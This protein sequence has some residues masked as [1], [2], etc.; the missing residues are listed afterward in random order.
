MGKTQCFLFGFNET[1]VVQPRRLSPKRIFSKICFYLDIFDYFRSKVETDSASAPATSSCS[2]Q[3]C[4]PVIRDQREHGKLH[5][6]ATQWLHN[7]SIM[8][9]PEL[10]NLFDTEPV[11]FGVNKCLEHPWGGVIHQV[12]VLLYCIISTHGRHV[13]SKL[14]VI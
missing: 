2:H 9:H 14:T 4:L 7:M 6:I 8:S 10:H 1:P 3:S 13:W 12:P 11:E 5:V